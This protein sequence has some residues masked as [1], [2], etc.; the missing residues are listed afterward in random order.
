MFAA[1]GPFPLLLAG[2][3][4]RAL[5]GR[6]TAL[7]VPAVAERLGGRAPAAAQ[8]DRAVLLMRREVVL[9]AVGVDQRD[10][11]LDPVGAVLADLDLDVGH[12]CIFAAPAGGP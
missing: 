4:H 3:R 12:G 8:R 7:R 2:F 1:G 6:E 11:A 10:R 9:V 5:R